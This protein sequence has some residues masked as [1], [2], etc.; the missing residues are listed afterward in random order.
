MVPPAHHISDVET[1]VEK[2]KQTFPRLPREEASLNSK[3]LASIC[4][5]HY[6]L[7]KYIYS[8]NTR[9]GFLRGFLRI[10]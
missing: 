8:S 7:Y 3:F 6:I 4:S 10:A 5:L 2:D 1:E 9:S